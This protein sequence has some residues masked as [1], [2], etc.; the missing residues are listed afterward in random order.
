MSFLFILYH[1]TTLW[2]WLKLLPPTKEN[3][4]CWEV[5]G[6]SIWVTLPRSCQCWNSSVILVIFL[7]S[8]SEF[9]PLPARLRPKS[10]YF[11][12]L[13]KVYSF[14]Y[15]AE[16]YCSDCWLCNQ[17]YR[18]C[19][20]IRQENSLYARSQNSWMVQYVSI[21]T[22]FFIILPQCTVTTDLKQANRDM[23]EV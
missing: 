22:Q 1:A 14:W 23:T 20:H 6:G 13:T 11:W 17:H 3:K 15:A 5:T 2:L 4:L 21:W 18:S 16:S 8:I 9:G 10:V 12:W 19:W 7:C